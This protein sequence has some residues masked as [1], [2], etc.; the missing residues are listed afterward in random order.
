MRPA[1]RP[2]SVLSTLLVQCINLPLVIDLF[3]VGSKMSLAW[4]YHGG[5]RI[6]CRNA[7]RI[8][9]RKVYKDG[10]SEVAIVFRRVDHLSYDVALTL[11]RTCILMPPTAPQ[12]A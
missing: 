9:H 11:L 12:M 5:D 2:A 1:G 3:Y 7:K 8:F 4:Q 6:Q 10:V